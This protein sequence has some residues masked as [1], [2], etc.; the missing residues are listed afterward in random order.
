LSVTEL[1]AGSVPGVVMVLAVPLLTA[2][3]QEEFE[4]TL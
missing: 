3:V 4:Y 1:D 2:V